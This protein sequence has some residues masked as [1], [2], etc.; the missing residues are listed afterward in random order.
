VYL[1]RHPGAAYYDDFK[2]FG[3]WRLEVSALRY[4][5]GYGRMSWVESA[6]WRAARPDPLLPDAAGILEHMN[7]DHADALPLYC[8]AFSRASEVG[9]VRMTAIDRLGFE[10]SAETPE[11]ARTVRVAFNEPI[12]TK[13][14]ARKALVGLLKEARAKLGAG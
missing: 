6:E 1:A 7:Q 13:N 3:Y 11:G 10:L 4:I 9:A 2:D 14:D 12:A 5:G 8:R